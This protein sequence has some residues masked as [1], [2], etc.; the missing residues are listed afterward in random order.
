MRSKSA[1][2]GCTS[3]HLVSN[4]KVRGNTNKPGILKISVVAEHFKQGLPPLIHVNST[5]LIL[6]TMP[7]EQ[8]LIRQEYYGHPRNLFWKLIAV[9]SGQREPQNYLEKVEM[10]KSGGIALWDVCGSC[11]RLGSLDSAIVDE[12]PNDLSVFLKEHD[13]IKTIAFN[14]R[15][16][17]VLFDTYFK[18]TSAYNYLSLPSSSPANAGVS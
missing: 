15:K 6:G 9:V 11:C 3:N 10:L 12:I 16:A 1:T 2:M 17:E 14:S 18:R 13:K 4:I 5:L 7:G 8:S